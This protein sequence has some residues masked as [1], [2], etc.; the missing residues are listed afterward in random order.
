LVQDFLVIQVE[1]C[2]IGIDVLVNFLAVKH[3]LDLPLAP[4]F[5]HSVVNDISA[6]DELAPL[7]ESKVNE[8][9]FDHIELF[10]TFL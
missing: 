1:L 4:H 5:I 10:K 3:H 6:K 2:H 8:N 9:P 7:S